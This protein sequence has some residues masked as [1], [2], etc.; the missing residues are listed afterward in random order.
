MDFDVER[1]LEENPENWD[2]T[3]LLSAV[4]DQLLTN[5]Y[6]VELQR[7][8]FEYYEDDELYMTVRFPVM[9]R[10]KEKILK[11]ALKYKTRMA[12]CDAHNRGGAYDAALKYGFMKE[13]AKHMKSGRTFWTKEKVLKDALKYKTKQEWK[14]KSG[15]YYASLKKKWYKKATM[16]M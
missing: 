9:Y 16:H 8:E 6:E 11:D 5:P 10:L 2:N 14:S 15:A 13:A 1:K 12:W 3:R 4:L 7:P